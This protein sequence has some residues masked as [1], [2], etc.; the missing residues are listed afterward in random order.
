MK[1]PVKQ[2]RAG[3]HWRYLSALGLTL[4]GLASCLG[5]HGLSRRARPME[6]GVKQPFNGQKGG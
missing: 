1:T 4:R 6:S 3:Q 2:V 5:Q